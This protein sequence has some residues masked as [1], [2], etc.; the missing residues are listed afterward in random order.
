[1]YYNRFR[2]YDPELGQYITQDPIGLAGG[3]PTLYGYVGDPNSWVDPFGLANCRLNK[4]DRDAMGEKPF[5]GAHRHH[6]VRE[7][8]PRN[9]SEADRAVILNAQK[10]LQ[11][12]GIDINKSPHNFNWA[13]LGEG[14][15]TIPAAHF[16]WNKL[17]PFSVNP[18]QHVQDIIDVL[19]EL[20]EMFEGG[21]DNR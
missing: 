3:N 1:L 14:N 16:V 12:A 4:A 21:F 18:A 13:S 17:K 2:Y 5:K 11:D 8:A 6:I 19:N 15:H 7:N 9:W 10:V 20:G